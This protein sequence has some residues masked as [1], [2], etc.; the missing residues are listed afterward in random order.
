MADSH[1]Y[2]HYAHRGKKRQKEFM[3]LVKLTEVAALNVYHDFLYNIYVMKVVI[4]YKNKAAL[5]NVFK[6]L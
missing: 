3:G 6:N 5:Q 4:Y 1:S 2:V